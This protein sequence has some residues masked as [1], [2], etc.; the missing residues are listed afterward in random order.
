MT[1]WRQGTR[2]LNSVLLPGLLTC[3]VAADPCIPGK[4]EERESGAGS[5]A[6]GEPAGTNPGTNP[7]AARDCGGLV[8]GLWGTGDGG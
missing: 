5:K 6:A 4:G 8:R 2:E 7:Q 3:R 1:H